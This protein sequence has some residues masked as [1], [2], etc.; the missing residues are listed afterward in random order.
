MRDFQPLRSLTIHWLPQEWLQSVFICGER[1]WDFSGRKGVTRNW[2]LET[3]TVLT[4]QQVSLPRYLC[5]A[6]PGLGRFFPPTHRF[7]DGLTHAAPPALVRCV[8]PISMPIDGSRWGAIPN[9]CPRH[10]RSPARPGPKSDFPQQIRGSNV[11][12]GHSTPSSKGVGITTSKRGC[13]SG[14]EPLGTEY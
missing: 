11:L 12:F 8:A 6:P 13:Q 3:R 10:W 9:A 2:K 7:R 4:T 14:P 5:V 1:R